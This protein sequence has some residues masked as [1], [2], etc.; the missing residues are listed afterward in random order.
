LPPQ[1]DFFLA[2]LGIFDRYGS[3]PLFPLFIPGYFKT[4]TT[5]IRKWWYGKKGKSINKR[6]DNQIY[7]PQKKTKNSLCYPHARP[8]RPYIREVSCKHIQGVTGGTDQ[9]SGG[10]SLCETIPKKPKTPI[11]KVERFGR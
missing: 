5:R 9:I 11:P 4:E 3:I 2:S 1:A 6:L 8:D 7:S 10:C